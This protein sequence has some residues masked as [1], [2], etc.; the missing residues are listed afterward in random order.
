MDKENFY[1]SISKFYDE[2]IDFDKALIRRKELLS[3]F[4]SHDIAKANFY[5]RRLYAADL[6]CATGIDSIALSQLGIEVTSIDISGEM[7]KKAKA[8][9]EKFRIKLKTAKTDLAEIAPEFD[10]NFDLIISS[11]NTP[12]N[13]PFDKIQLVLDN[14]Y[15]I[16]KPAG[17]F[18]IQLL[19]Y[20]K[21]LKEKTPT[22]ARTKINNEEITRGYT[23]G[24]D[25]MK[26]NVKNSSS[27]FSS[28]IFPHR[29][30]EMKQYL[31]NSGFTKLEFF[32]GL[33]KSPFDIQTSKDL[34]ITG[35]KPE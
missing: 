22:F 9:A 32:G 15:R 23:Y 13:I 34:V 10:D 11:S 18:I 14:F 12:A 17:K 29:K 1:D 28:S 8:N 5:W 20:D 21:M 6:G 16:L 4:L 31:H 3:G 26:F 7:I 35:I 24:E 25:E 27:E 30:A 33:N 19:N 2:M